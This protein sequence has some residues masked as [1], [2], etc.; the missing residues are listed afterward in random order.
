MRHQVK[1]IMLGAGAAVSVGT[2]L[3]AVQ[4]RIVAWNTASQATLIASQR[5]ASC[6]P[7][8]F[9]KSNSIPTDYVSRQPFE[10]GTLVCDWQGRTGQINGYGAID[11]VR[12]GQAQQINATMTSRG[13]RNPGH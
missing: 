11:Y 7:L 5:A 3:A 1:R 6:V 2:A 12:Q 13:F 10:P 4:P 9:V 8:N